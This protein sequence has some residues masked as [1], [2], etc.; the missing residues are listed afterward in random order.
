MRASKGASLTPVQAITSKRQEPTWGD[1]SKFQTV[2]QAY[3]LSNESQILS[4]ILSAGVVMRHLQTI[5]NASAHTNTETIAE[6]RALSTF[7][8]AKPITLPGEALFW[9]IPSTG[10]FLYREWNGRM[11]AAANLAVQ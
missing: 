10:D 7:Y 8:V 3:S 5:R 1:V 6:V 11:I 4:G 9:A 2:A